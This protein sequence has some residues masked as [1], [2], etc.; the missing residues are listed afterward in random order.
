MTDPIRV[1][2]ADGT[3]IA[4]QRTGTGPAL[5][6]VDAAAHYRAFSSF[7]GLVSHLAPHLTVYEFDRRGRGDSGDSPPSSARSRTWPP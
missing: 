4:F 1:R 7:T 2:S 6:L 5:V 3:S